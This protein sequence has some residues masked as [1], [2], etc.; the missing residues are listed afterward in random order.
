MSIDFNAAD[1]RPH[2]GSVFRVVTGE[3][4]STELKLSE[5]GELP[6]TH[7]APRQNPYSLLFLG[8]L[9]PVLP[10]KI[11]CFTHS[12]L[13]KFDLFIV[14]VGPTP[15]GAMRYEAIFN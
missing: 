3:S 8:P 4:V 1:F 15:D 11:Y 14:P 9:A 7:G 5:V 10:Q 13:G 2:A 12:T 6:T